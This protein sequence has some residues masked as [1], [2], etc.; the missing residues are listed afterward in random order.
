MQNPGWGH[1][2]IILMGWSGEAGLE[3]GVSGRNAGTEQVVSD[4]T[5]EAG[6]TMGQDTGYT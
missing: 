5:Q 1:G 4:R 3:A 2:G 6:Q